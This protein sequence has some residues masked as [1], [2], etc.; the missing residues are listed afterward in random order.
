[1]SKERNVKCKRQRKTKT[2]SHALFVP[3]HGVLQIWYNPFIT[4]NPEEC[5]GIRKLGMATENLW[6]PDIF[7]EEL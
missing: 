2:S 4:W 7:I 6:L 3:Y 5:G 1:M